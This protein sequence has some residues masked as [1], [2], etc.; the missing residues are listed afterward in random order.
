MLPSPG[1][2]PVPVPQGFLAHTQHFSPTQEP[3]GEDCQPGEAG[4]GPV[5]GVTEQDWLLAVTL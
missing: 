4:V 3:V 2:Q 1:L 5:G